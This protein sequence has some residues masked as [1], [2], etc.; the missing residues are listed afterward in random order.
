[1]SGL[2]T[3][4]AVPTDPRTLFALCFA[5]SMNLVTLVVFQAAGVLHARARQVNFNVSLHVLLAIV[6]V[7]VPMVQCLLFT[8]RSRGA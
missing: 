6:L 4:I 8:Y 5:E 1:M 3:V 2:A 7:V